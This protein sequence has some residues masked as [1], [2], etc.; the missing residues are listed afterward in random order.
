MVRLFPTPTHPP[1]LPLTQPCVGCIAADGL[2]AL[3][4]CAPQQP[5]AIVAVIVDVH[6]STRHLTCLR[7]FAGVRSLTSSYTTTRLPRQACHSGPAH[8]P[9]RPLCPRHVLGGLHPGRLSHLAERC[10]GPAPGPW[11]A[12][13]QPGPQASPWGRW[14]GRGRGESNWY[15]RGQDGPV[16][17]HGHSALR[18]ATVVPCPAGSHSGVV[19]RGSPQWYHAQCHVQCPARTERGGAAIVCRPCCSWWNL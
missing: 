2:Y 5:R 17:V 16:W 13:P 8:L 3:D 12:A 7:S 9:L 19:S 15:A 14:G 18:E 1:A 11:R 10:R 4:L 6:I